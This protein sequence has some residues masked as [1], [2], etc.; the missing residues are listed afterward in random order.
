VN[1]RSTD[2]KDSVTE[3]EELR[4][5]CTALREQNRQLLR[6]LGREAPEPSTA[7]S[8]RLEDVQT[9]THVGTWT[10]DFGEEDLVLR[11]V[12][13]E[14]L[15]ESEKRMA[16][17]A[18]A[19]QMGVWDYDVN[20]NRLTW[21]AQMH[22]LYG[23]TPDT[24]SHAVD[25]WQNG[26]HPDDRARAIEVLDVAVRDHAEFHTTF[27]IVWPSGEVRDLEAHGLA[28]RSA[29]DG[30]V[31][32]FGVNRDITS[33]TR[34]DEALR[35]SEAELRQKVA[36]LRI[37]G[38]AARLGGWS[39]PV[40]GTHVVW[41]DVVCSI[42][43]VPPGT[44]PTVE[45]GIEYYAPEFQPLV[46]EKFA[47]CVRDGT[48]YD[49]ELQVVTAKKRKVWVRAI[50][51]AER[52][53]HGAIVAVSGAFQDI[54]DRRK[55]QEQ[56]RQSQKMEAIGRLAGGVAHDFNNLLSV[57][58][59]YAD[60]SLDDLAPG[61][62]LRNNLEQVLAA[63]GRATD[64]TRQLLAFSRQQV[65]QPRVI[66]LD[67][68]LTG[69]NA[70]LGRLLGA[71]IELSVLRS[72]KLGRVLADA[73]QIEQVVMNLAVN[74]RDA[75]AY[76]GKL[77]I[78]MKNVQLEGADGDGKT[79]RAP[80]AY[81]MLAIT[82]TGTGMD[83][84]TRARIFEPFF[85]TKE[86]G[87]GTGLGLATVFGIVQQSGGYLDV[88]SEVGHGTTFK[89]YFPRTDQVVAPSPVPTSRSHLRGTETILL[90][91][92]EEP[93]R[94]VACVILRRSGYHV[95]DARD[96]DEAIRIAQDFDGE[97][98]MLLTDVVMPRMSGRV[99]A[100]QLLPLRPAMRLAFASGYT[101]D[102]IVHHGVLD[103][104]VP[105][106]Q[107]PFTPDAL[108]RKVREVLDRS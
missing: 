70:M 47:A 95:L 57:I 92:D 103:A 58:I 91:E 21:D 99:L 74:A 35:V 32:V 106:L 101:D 72:P 19:A 51:Q 90:V 107:K 25:A 2:E 9:V 8:L 11:K 89:I 18:R 63:C 100:D 26:L 83:A 79:T 20:Q 3:L 31:R 14:R 33:R 104:G 38:N 34:A 67:E 48:P 45:D 52:D 6:E 43:E 69:M 22:V 108:L 65:L 28:L 68:A 46:R 29:E 80:G 39:V 40:G 10:A 49:L 93:L 86:Q 42:H 4:R 17:A 27:R 59:S 5:E 97:I 73:G 30:S 75:M 87:K 53:A 12:A 13:V 81:V 23:V 7:S 61:E 96:G 16:I 78:E 1:G 105:F 85:T 60:L 56:L 66:D 54:D 24:F 82:D 50:G 41:S 71:D 44:R 62:P 84:A 98:H 94:I 15:R 36:L 77:T 37:A 102:A 88:Y 76:G 64:L 55:L